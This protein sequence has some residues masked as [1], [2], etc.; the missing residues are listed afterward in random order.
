MKLEMPTVR[1]KLLA[2]RDSRILDLGRRF[3][4]EHELVAPRGHAGERGVCDKVDRCFLRF[5]DDLAE[6][7][8]YTKQSVVRRAHGSVLLLEVLFYGMRRG[9]D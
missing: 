2:F 1:G 6:P 7:A 5:F 4:G 8:R 3:D 9:H